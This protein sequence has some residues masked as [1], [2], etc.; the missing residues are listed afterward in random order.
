MRRAALRAALLLA[1]APPPGRGAPEEPADLYALL[2]VPSDA[3]AADIRRAF[4]A[5]AGALHP[6][7]CLTG[8]ERAHERMSALNEA[9]ETLSSPESRE[10]YDAYGADSPDLELLLRV[11]PAA[12][13]ADSHGAPGAPR[14]HG[15]APPPPRLR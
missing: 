12:A 3:S 5:R 13:Y 8:C 1:L 15:R 10:R 11:P 2:G 14:P 9:Y 7:K 4:R 6:D